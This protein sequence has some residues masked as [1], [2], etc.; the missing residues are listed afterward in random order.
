MIFQPP[1][2]PKSMKNGEKPNALQC[3]CDFQIF[4][5]FRCV[6]AIWTTFSLQNVCKSLPWGHLGTF[7]ALFFASLGR[8]LGPTAL[9]ER[10]LGAS[11]SQTVLPKVSKTTPNTIF[12]SKIF[13]FP[14]P[15]RSQGHGFRLISADF[16]RFSTILIDFYRFSVIFPSFPPLIPNAQ[17]PMPNTQFL[18][19]IPNP[20]WEHLDIQSSRHQ[21]RGR[22][23]ARSD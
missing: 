20:S 1:D 7:L 15:G 14:H 6:A 22:R 17:S 13:K 8:C 16:H 18:F 9:S 2:T 23:N 10:C 11:W 5:G 19:S 12:R 21:S 3:F 4:M